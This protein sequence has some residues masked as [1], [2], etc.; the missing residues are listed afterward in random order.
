M[1]SFIGILTAL[2]VA[3]SIPVGLFGLLFN[4]DDGYYVDSETA[5]Y[6]DWLCNGRETYQIW[7]SQIDT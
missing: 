4:S 2:L 3:I 7:Y 5:K 1:E 6:Y